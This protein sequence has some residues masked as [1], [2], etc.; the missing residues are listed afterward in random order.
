[1]SLSSSLQALGE[2]SNEMLLGSMPPLLDGRGYVADIAILLVNSLGTQCL[3]VCH[4]EGAAR[5]Q[6][7]RRVAFSDMD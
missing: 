2:V 4:L 1:M 5:E 7:R 3:G 6:F